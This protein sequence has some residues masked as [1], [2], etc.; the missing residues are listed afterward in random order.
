MKTTFQRLRVSSLLVVSG[1]IIA[2]LVELFSFRSDMRFHDLITTVASEVS[3]R[4]EQSNY[5][6]F[7]K[8]DSESTHLLGIQ[9]G[10]QIREYLPI[11]IETLRMAG[12][13][14]VVFDLFF[15]DEEPDLDPAFAEALSKYPITISGAVQN[16]NQNNAM[17][18]ML[19]EK[20]TDLGLLTVGQIG[21]IPR[22]LDIEMVT[23][24]T[25]VVTLPIS[26]IAAQYYAKA[27]EIAVSDMFIPQTGNSDKAVRYWIPF[28]KPISYF[29][30]FSLVHVV[31]ADGERLA[32]DRRT[33][34]S[35]F[36]GKAVFVGYDLPDRDQYV[37]PNTVGYAVP[38]AYGHIYAFE[39]ILQNTKLVVFTFGK[40]VLVAAVLSICVSLVL[41]MRHKR[42]RRLV[43]ITIITMWF[44]V[45]TLI[46]AV[47]SLQLPL[48]SI[49]C[50]VLACWMVIRVINRVKLKSD[51]Q[52]AVGFDPEIL[53]KFRSQQKTEN[54]QIRRTAAILCSDMR[55]YTAF[56]NDNDIDVVTEVLNDYF[57][58]M[59]SIISRNGGYV[60]K[61]VGDEIMAV[62]GFPYSE[63]DM[64]LR[65]YH[66]AL[67][68]F[69]GLSNLI[70]K[71]E[72]D[73]RPHVS[74]IGIGLDFGEVT[75]LEFG[76][77]SKRQ[78]DIIGN[79]ING[80]SRLQALTKTVDFPLAL[81][82]EFIDQLRSVQSREDLL[83]QFTYLGPCPIKGQGKRAVYGYRP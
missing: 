5:S 60:N 39:G 46:S 50:S 63:S 16:G 11:L 3:D 82:R 72:Q 10:S 1:I 29:P 78:F 43:F 59:D 71:W 77:R 26:L 38:G 25:T 62:F 61:L 74:A 53:D 42:L 65:A 9:P 15:I 35:I 12:A 34:I 83:E 79:A 55:D 67:D 17:P 68:M 27:R 37:L 52:V 20:I 24:D 64:G 66:C 14:A 81:S 45:V 6:V 13:T 70:R 56:V 54:G 22:Y 44:F 32:D 19:V 31:Q 7:V 58:E 51:L 73:N 69:S 41:Q 80:A 30:S 36:A 23:S 4:S 28:R 49:F 76:G 75:F 40:R 2:A 18:T 8:I 33:P 21:N 48:I 47:T 57:A